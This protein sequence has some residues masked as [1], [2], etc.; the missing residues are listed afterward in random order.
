[1][2]AETKEAKAEKKLSI[3]ESVREGL[4]A[5]AKG[6]G[7]AVTELWIIF[8]RQ[9]VVR[10]LTEVFTGVVL[11]VAAY[12]LFPVIGLWVLVP[13]ALA[14]VF[15]Y[16]SIQLLG[17]PRYFALEDIANRIQDFKN[18]DEVTRNAVDWYNKRYR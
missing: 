13:L 7:I 15:F 5:I 18:Q 6:I 1:M 2:T 14:M 3:P 8:V 9:Y 10:G 17:N 12:F 4:E 11:C 16:G